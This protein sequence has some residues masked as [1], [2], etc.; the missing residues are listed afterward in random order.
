MP[1]YIKQT[2]AA[3]IKKQICAVYNNNGDWRELA[4]NIGVKRST[5]YRWLKN[6]DRIPM[7]RGGKRRTKITEEHREFIVQYVEENNKITLKELRQK[8]LTD[9]QIIV[10]SE[11]LRKHLDGLLYT[12]KDVRREPERL[13]SGETKLRRKEY[14][15]QLLNYQSE[16]IPV[17]YLDETNFNLFISRR[18]GR[19][20]KGTRCRYI[21]AGSRG[22]NVHVIGCIGNMGLIHHEIRRGAFRREEAK[23]FVRNCLRAAY[24]IHQTRVV[25]V[26]DNAPCHAGLEEVFQEP[27]FQ[28]H[29]LLRLSPY[30]PMLNPIEF[31]WSSF[32]AAVKRA[33]SLRLQ[34]IL[35][36]EERTNLPQNQYRLSELEIILRD[37][38]N[39]ININNCARYVA[40]IQ[41]Y[42]PDVLNLVDMVV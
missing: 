18:Q 12:L 35:A 32:K 29:L 6:Q 3:N 42:F 16:N 34:Q 4:N 39:I 10:S 31:A 7:Q 21:S 36:G 13:N 2:E 23:E 1:S 15:Q 26:V 40:H 22:A 14:V 30:S 19:S 11:C 37:N 33:M 25:L 38:I 24:N 41:R 20:K 9:H 28:D 27:E 8:F 17:T 5:A